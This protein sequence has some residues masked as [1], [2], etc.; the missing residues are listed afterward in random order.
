LADCEKALDLLSAKIDGELSSGEEAELAAHLEHCESCRLLAS[1][2]ESIHAGMQSFAVSPPAGLTESVLGKI[3][4]ENYS[5]KEEKVVLMPLRKHAWRMWLSMAAAFLLIVAGIRFLPLIG[6][7]GASSGSSMSASAPTPAPTLSESQEKTF[8]SENTAEDGNVGS[9]SSMMEKEAVTGNADTGSKEALSRSAVSDA[10]GAGAA[11]SEVPEISTPEISVPESSPPEDDENSGNEMT[12]QA[13]AGS[14]RGEALTV[15][16]AAEALLV[17]LYPEVEVNSA[18]L[19]DEDGNF[20]GLE[21]TDQA[22]THISTIEYQ[23]ETG[24]AAAFLFSERK[25]ESEEGTLWQVTICG[26][27]ITEVTK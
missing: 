2:L 5:P 11:Q 20:T 14:S 17:F 21:V 15:Q 25:E 24:D 16:N 1:E 6:S 3:K 23:G 12:F 4:E 26:G 10:A 8:G 27:E 22:G 13:V 19:T 18:E 7:G 9:N